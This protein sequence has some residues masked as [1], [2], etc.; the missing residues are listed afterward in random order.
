MP[1]VL[2]LGPHNE[3]I[4]DRKD[5]LSVAVHAVQLLAKVLIILACLHPL[6]EQ[7]WGDVDLSPKGIRGV[8]PQE[9]PE[10]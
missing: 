6:L 2:G 9:Q 4:E 3:Q 7:P 1:S 8:A 10:K 5:S